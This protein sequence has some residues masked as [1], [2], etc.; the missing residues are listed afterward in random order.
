LARTGILVTIG[1]SSALPEFSW[2]GELVEYL[3]DLIVFVTDPW[4][5]GPIAWTKEQI[6]SAIIQA[7][8]LVY[9]LYRFLRLRPPSLGE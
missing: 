9:F 2:N 6:L 7:A 4:T 5:T 3:T 8:L 1:R